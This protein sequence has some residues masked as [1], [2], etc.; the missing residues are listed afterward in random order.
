MK[1]QCVNIKCQ[2]C[3]DK[4]KN[5]LAQ[6]YPDLEVDIPQQIVEVNVNEEQLKE[7]QNKLQEL[8]F[9]QP[10]GIVGKIKNFF[11]H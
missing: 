6:K 3:V 4:I 11:T 10:Q 2:G 9:L 7:I 8:G 1:I 5:A